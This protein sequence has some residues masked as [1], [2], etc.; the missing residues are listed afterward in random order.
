MRTDR[1]PSS[2]LWIALA[3]AIAG[4]LAAAVGT[5]TALMIVHEPS[6]IGGTGLAAAVFA[7]L[8]LGS[9]LFLIGFAA[10]LHILHAIAVRLDAVGRA[11]RDDGDRSPIT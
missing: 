11:G 5:A 6:A 8:G 10:N 4:L 1:L 7:G 9:G 3:L 2:T